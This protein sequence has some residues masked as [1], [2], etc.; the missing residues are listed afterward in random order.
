MDSKVNFILSG[1]YPS[2]FTKVRFLKEDCVFELG[3]W[4]YCRLCSRGAWRSRSGA[5]GGQG[6]EK[7]GAVYVWMVNNSLKGKT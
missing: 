1:I 7:F 6:P 5:L 2:S 3:F 4:R